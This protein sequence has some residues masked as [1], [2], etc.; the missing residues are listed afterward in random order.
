MVQKEAAMRICA[1]P[2]T[3]ESGAISLAIRYYSNP[4]ILF[5]VSREN[6]IPKPNVDSTVIKLNIRKNYTV[7]INNE[8]FLFE[9]IKK[10]F[11][12]RRKTILNALSSSLNIDKNI[13][14]RILKNLDINEQFRPEQLNLEQFGLISDNLYEFKNI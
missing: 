7:N 9:I 4:E 10:S 6:F 13:V 1:K 8:I 11:S 2:G 3:R 5:E 12:K 14:S